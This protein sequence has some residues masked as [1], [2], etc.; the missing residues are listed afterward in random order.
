MRR[1]IE[2]TEKQE[3]KERSAPHI[4]FPFHRVLPLPAIAFPPTPMDTKQHWKIPLESK[5][6]TMSCRI[7]IYTLQEDM[8]QSPSSFAPFS[9]VHHRQTPN[10]VYNLQEPRIHGHLWNRESQL[11]ITCFTLSI[12]TQM[13][14]AFVE[15]HLRMSMLQK[16][17]R[18][19]NP[20]AVL[21]LEWNVLI[22]KLPSLRKWIGT[23]PFRNLEMKRSNGGRLFFVTCNKSSEKY[24]FKKHASG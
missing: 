13:P 3:R 18:Q 16:S 6:L 17:S 19:S 12:L 22:I 1:M 14:V 2:E 23:F 8:D 4:L 24:G 7:Y 9:P 20:I 10:R 15:I 5:H 11:F 21:R